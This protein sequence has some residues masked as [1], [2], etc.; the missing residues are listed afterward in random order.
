MAS[1]VGPRRIIKDTQRGGRASRRVAVLALAIATSTA[2]SACGNSDGSKDSAGASTSLQIAV[3]GHPID[4][5]SVP[6]ISGMDAGC[7]KKE[8]IEISKISGS[9]GGGDTV[10]NV[11]SG[12]L[13]FGDVSPV[14]AIQAFQSGSPVVIVGGGAQAISTV[15]YIAE[16]D[17]PLTS[18]D[19]LPGNTVAFTSPGSVTEAV[20]RLSLSRAGVDINDIKTRA[21]GG[22]GEG[23]TALTGGGVDAAAMVEPTLSSLPDDYKVLWSASDYIKD[24]QKSVIIS[25]KDYVAKNPKAVKNFL[26]GRACGVK[27]LTDDT[28]KAAELWGKELR[29]EPNLVEPVLKESISAGEFG[30]GLSVEGLRTLEESMRQLGQLKVDE[31]VD[32]DTLIDQDYLP[33]GTA[34]IDPSKL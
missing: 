17:S 18:I 24:F 6:Y 27:T 30:V 13:P 8:G 21:A 22:I 7:F 9:G 26:A 3:S 33:E 15:K 4:T 5:L 32:W 29:I 11:L 16:K 25:S 12:D 34:T 20:L 1:P 2:M 14:A 10:R 28:A 19:D 31:K 23:L